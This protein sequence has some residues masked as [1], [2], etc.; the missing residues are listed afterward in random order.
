MAGQQAASKAL[1]AERS[2]N[3]A[4][5]V[6]D[7][8]GAPP[9]T[10]AVDAAQQLLTQPDDAEAALHQMPS[11]QWEALRRRVESASSTCSVPL[12]SPD[13]STFL[14]DWA[15]YSF[16]CFGGDTRNPFTGLTAAQLKLETREAAQKV[17]T[18][19]AESAII[20]PHAAEIRQLQAGM[21]SAQT[22]LSLR[23]GGRNP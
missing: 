13:S 18:I 7:A 16:S 6:A 14:Q 4:A 1:A 19:R 3:F 10:P 15:T 12:P 23:Y 2:G 11:R 21:R 9:R 8:A 22:A 20:A 5:V 17:R